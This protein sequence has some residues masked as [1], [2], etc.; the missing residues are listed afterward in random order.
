MVAVLV[1]AISTGF[2]TCLV[3]EGMTGR[4]VRSGIGSSFGCTYPHD[5]VLALTS[6]QLTAPYS[7]LPADA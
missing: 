7:C 5:W 6:Q 1:T 4:S 2:S 3:Y